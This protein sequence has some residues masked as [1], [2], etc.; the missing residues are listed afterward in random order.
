MTSLGYPLVGDPAYGR[1]RAGRLKALPEPVRMA[2]ADFS[3]Q[4]LHAYLLGFDHPTKGS[5]VRFESVMPADLAGLIST[6]ET[7]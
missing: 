5:R 6:L 1:S 2:L 7:I 4:A 3:R